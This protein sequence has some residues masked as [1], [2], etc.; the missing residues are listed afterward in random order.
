MKAGVEHQSGTLI[1][2]L[3]G[4]LG[5]PDDDHEDLLERRRG[6]VGMRAEAGRYLGQFA[7]RIRDLS[8]EE[9]REL[10]DETLA[11]IASPALGHSSTSG[12]RVTVLGALDEAL[13]RASQAP[14]GA[15]DTLLLDHVLPAIERILPSLEA[16]RNPYALLLKSIC[17]AVLD[18][19]QGTDARRN[20]PSCGL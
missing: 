5:R 14:P 12:A 15:S 9:R 13:Q 6:A 17:F 11:A 7:E 3:G 4:L 1:G 19:L 2:L 8:V 18:H 20:L 10:Y 16:A